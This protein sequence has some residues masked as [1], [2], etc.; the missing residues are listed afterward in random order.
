MGTRMAPSYANLFM[1]KL[2]QKFL[3]TQN[4]LPLVWWRYIDD[5]FAIWTHGVPCLNVFLRELN[6]YHTT[7]KFT[8]DWLAHEVTLLLDT[9]VYIKDGRVQTDLHIKP[10]NKRQYLPTKSCHPKHYKT[11]IPYNQALRIKRICLEQENLSLRTNQL[12]HHL[13][14]RGYSDQLLDSEI[15]RAIST[16]HGSSS[17]SRSNWQ[18][19]NHAPLVVT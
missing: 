12:K 1:E 2:E 8:A 13:S 6:N 9:R 14:K 4:K 17:P 18:T 3:Q 16:S 7:N 11:A 15:N 5:A 19:L 10:T